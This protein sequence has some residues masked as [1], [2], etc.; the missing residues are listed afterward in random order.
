M[1]ERVTETE[2]RA[3]L[4]QHFN[5]EELE[6]LCADLQS[7]LAESG[8]GVRVDL[9]TVGGESYPAQV[10]NLV[11]FLK[12]RNLLAELAAEIEHE[13]P[14]LLR[15]SRID[16]PREARLAPASSS[17]GA[18]TLALVVTLCML[19]TLISAFVCFLVWAQIVTPIFLN[20]TIELVALPAALLW[21]RL[22]RRQF[23]G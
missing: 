3:A 14:G 8:V 6:Q 19:I 15:A 10:L 18:V 7:R 5:R 22:A 23:S 9:A 17:D 21:Q 2:L 20:L 1:S 12:R 4:E 16:V 13:R 11:T